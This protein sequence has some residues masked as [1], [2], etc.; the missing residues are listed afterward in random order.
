M[1]SS[2]E[3]DSLVKTNR[4]SSDMASLNIARIIVYSKVKIS[5]FNLRQISKFI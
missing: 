1:N 4:N 2:V 5:L 3:V